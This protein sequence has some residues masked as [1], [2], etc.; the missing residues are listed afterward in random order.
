MV[1]TGPTPTG[2]AFAPEPSF[3][4]GRRVFLT[5]HT[6]FKGSW[7]AQW[8]LD[9]GAE[10]RGYA[11]A[12]D[13]DPALFDVLQLA[14]RMDSVIADILD[15][16]RLQRA[17]A[18]FRPEI[19]I[20]MAAQPLVRRSYRE[21]VYTFAVNAQG[22]VHVLE[23][24]RNQP[25]LRAVVVVTTDKCYLNHGQGKPY[26]E[27]DPLGGHDPY[28]ASKAC[29]EIAAD[30]YRRSFFT[31]TSAAAIASARAGN[32]FGGGDWAEDRL[33]PDAARALARGERL[34]VRNPDFI[35]PWQHVVEPLQGYLMLA[36]ALVEHRATYA[37]A[38]NFGPPASRAATVRDV[39][40][41]ICK[42]W[43]GKAA[44]RH[45][46]AGDNMPE[47]LLLTLDSTRAAN[48][49][50]WHPAADLSPAIAAT[51][52]WYRKFYSGA[53]VEDLIEDMRATLRHGI[54]AG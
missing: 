40:D 26:V 21:P 35:R 46:A 33:I 34:R 30:A 47:A 17:I 7:L 50:G 20:H 45:E 11:L 36:R 43:G 42:A 18:E 8:L 15:R 13:T 12:P 54:A 1:L 25:D 52:Q 9:L 32:V 49:L 28:S 29:A 44:W 51:A 24:C 2:T 3:W 48:D 14:A 10:L 37:R 38:Y 39:A 6:G 23:A 19:V 22:T 16:D 27:D 53:P 31:G 41:L 4:R 5:G